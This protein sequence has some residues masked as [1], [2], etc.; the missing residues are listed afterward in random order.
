MLSIKQTRRLNTLVTRLLNAETQLHRPESLTGDTFEQAC[1]KK[2][3]ALAAYHRFIETL[4][5]PRS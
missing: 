5:E 2:E 1:A 3:K 4:K